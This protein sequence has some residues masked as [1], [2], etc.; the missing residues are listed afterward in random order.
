MGAYVCVC[1]CVNKDVGRQFVR[2]PS[3][4]P[5]AQETGGGLGSMSVNVR[6]GVYVWVHALAQPLWVHACVC[7][8]ACVRACAFVCVC[9]HTHT[10]HTHIYMCV[11]VCVY[12]CTYGHGHVCV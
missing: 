8:R 11:C 5:C 4:G 3:S 1:V 6:G 9:T 2:E 12:V 10:K 7:V